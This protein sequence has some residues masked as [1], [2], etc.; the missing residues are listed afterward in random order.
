[1][2]SIKLGRK[3]KSS[4]LN[5]PSAF[6]VQVGILCLMKR[7]NLPDNWFPSDIWVEEVVLNK[8]VFHWETKLGWY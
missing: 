1:M 5:L 2:I 8:V 7:N 3:K 4:D 6:S